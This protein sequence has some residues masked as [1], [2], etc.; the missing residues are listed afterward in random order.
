MILIGL[1][2]LL[3]FILPLM[4]G[5]PPVFLFMAK[6][7]LVVA[8][9]CFIEGAFVIWQAVQC[10]KK[11][12]LLGYDKL[13]DQIVWEDRIPL[14]KQRGQIMVWLIS[15]CILIC[16]LS[17]FTPYAKRTASFA[18]PLILFFSI[19]YCMILLSVFRIEQYLRNIVKDV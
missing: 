3:F 9:L 12:K 10:K 8:I 13:K 11:F 14:L 7:N 1:L 19:F 5:M 6:S 17:L 18:V 15:I 2:F 4:V 16:L